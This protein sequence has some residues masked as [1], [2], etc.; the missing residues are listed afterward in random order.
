[1]GTAGNPP[2]LR[3]VDPHVEQT[4][5][6]ATWLEL[7]SDLVFVVAVAELAHLLADQVSG[8]RMLAYAGL[9]V[10]VWWAWVGGTFYNNRFDSDDTLHRILTLAQVLAVAVLAAAIHNAVGSGSATFALA[11][12]VV[13]LVLVLEY[14]RAGIHVEAARP[15]IRRYTTGFTVAL[16]IWVASTLVGEPARYVLW[17]AAMVIDLGTALSAR[18]YQSLLPPQ[19]QHLPERFGLF[20]VIVLGESI[21]SIVRGLSDADVTP[22]T[23]AS[24]AAGVV[25]A[26]GIWWLYF[27]NLEESV[28]LRTQVAGQVW[29]YSH[30]LLLI[31]V[32]AVGVGIEVGIL[33]SRLSEAERWLIGGSVASTLG[34]LAIL[35]LCSDR[36]EKATPRLV[37]A[38]ACVVAAMLAGANGSLGL[39][40]ILAAVVAAQVG[41]E[42]V[43]KARLA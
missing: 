19:P 4:A 27:E 18:R 37:G 14:L 43:K 33:H 15:L 2:R 29:V 31:A 20:V 38:A 39:L 1:M 28:V 41:L 42:L 6:R 3:L 8:A 35:H 23:L 26:F 5:R 9:F 36:P 40:G 24:A 10:P 17:A 11:Y 7:F 21:A 32:A 12:S 22:L 13:R 16:A 30:L 34:V 25:L